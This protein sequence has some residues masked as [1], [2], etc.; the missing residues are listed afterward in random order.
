VTSPRRRG[1]APRFSRE[2]LVDAAL[3]VVEAQG[4]AAL[5]LRSVARELGA[6]PM[7]LYTYVDS[8]EELAA[9]V[10]DRLV[11]DAIKGTRWPRTWKGVLK[12]LARRLDALV[13]AHPA[14]VEAYG[15]GMVRSGVASEFVRDVVERLEAGGLTPTRAREAYVAVHAV[16]LGFALIRSEGTTAP[17]GT[18]ATASS[19]L[20]DRLVDTLLVGFEP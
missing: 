6:G 1:P 20:L 17:G 12:L 9:L 13:S 14:M 3:G 16:V 7:T 19:A 5:S 11:A 18:R 10:I 15:R 8:S 4:F 2:Q